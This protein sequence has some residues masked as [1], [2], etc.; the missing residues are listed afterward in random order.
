MHVGDMTTVC[1][2]EEVPCP[3]DLIYG[4]AT[5]VVEKV[6]VKRDGVV[7]VHARRVKTTADPTEMEIMHSAGTRR[8]DE[9]R[10]G[11]PRPRS[12]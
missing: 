5:A 11:F 12:E 3:G 7:R 2:L 10:S 1:V 8:S 4:N 6:L 9:R